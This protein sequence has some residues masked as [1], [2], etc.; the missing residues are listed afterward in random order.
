M[1][2]NTTGK[3]VQVPGCSFYEYDLRTRTIPAGRIYFDVATLLH[4]VGGVREQ[5]RGMPE[6]FQP[7]RQLRVV[8][9]GLGDAADHVDEFAGGA[10]VAA[11]Q[12]LVGLLQKGIVYFIDTRGRRRIGRIVGQ[13]LAVQRECVGVLRLVE[14]AVVESF[15]GLLQGRGDFLRGRRCR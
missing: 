9:A 12:R 1:T 3:A 6:R 15:V 13:H 7:R 2:A 14:M 8:V 4:Q 10:F 11:I 5:R